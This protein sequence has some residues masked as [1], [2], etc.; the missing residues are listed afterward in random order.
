MKFIFIF[1]LA[2]ANSALAMDC[3]IQHA[4]EKENEYLSYALPAI[5]EANP[6][7][8]NQTNLIHIS[9]FDTFIFLPNRYFI[10]AKS[11]GFSLIVNTRG[12]S[13][14]YGCS[15]QAGEFFSGTIRYGKIESCDCEKPEDLS[16]TDLEISDHQINDQISMRLISS[17]SL[18][19][20]AAYIF[21]KGSYM[22]ISDTN[23]DL[24]KH[25]LF[26]LKGFK[27]GV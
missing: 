6:K 13:D 26:Q 21:F 15:L 19:V 27:N 9:V 17:Q 10:T 16:G 25:V 1:L 3:T 11:D 14:F 12:R 23:N 8:R 24:Y 5:A 18:S 2:V 22:H 7:V 20:V 4:I